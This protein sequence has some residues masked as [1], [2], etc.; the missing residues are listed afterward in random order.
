MREGGEK[1]K[2]WCELMTETCKTRMRVNLWN[3]HEATTALGME[4]KGKSS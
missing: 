2:N 4:T 1:S 3:F